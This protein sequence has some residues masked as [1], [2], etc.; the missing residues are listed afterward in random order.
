MENL[1][2]FGST[3]ALYSGIV[4]LVWRH[5][6]GSPI[7]ARKTFKALGL[8]ALLAMPINI[9]GYVFTIAGNAVGEKGVFSLFSL[10]QK[11]PGTAFVV[12]PLFT[13]Q[14]AGN[15][16]GAFV[17]IVG[18]QKAGNMAVVGIG[19]AVNQNA[20]NEVGVI[21]GIGFHQRV[22]EKERVFGAFTPLTVY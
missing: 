16:A 20:Q 11:T 4:L 1:W 22:G 21:L 10:Y 18:N 17:G 12:F 7:P 6:L 8:I 2:L 14:E 9:N 5:K 15:D 13:W 19:F 3:V